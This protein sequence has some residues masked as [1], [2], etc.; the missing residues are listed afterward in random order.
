MTSAIRKEFAA[1]PTPAGDLYRS[2]GLEFVDIPLPTLAGN[3]QD[4]LYSHEM[5]NVDSPRWDLTLEQRHVV[6]QANVIVMDQHI[7][8]PLFIAPEENL[9]ECMRDILR[10]INWVQGTY[11]GVEHY[12]NRLAKKKSSEA[13]PFVLTRAGAL[14]PR[15]MGQYVFGYVT[16]FE[17]KLLEAIDFRNKGEYARAQMANFRL[18]ENV[19]IGILGFGE[20]GQGIGKMLRS[21]GYNVIGFKRRIGANLELASSADHVTADLN[22]VLSKSDYLVNVLPSTSSTQYLLNETNLKLCHER[23]PTFINIGR[24]DVASEETIISALNTGM[25]SR[26]V[27]DVFEQEPLPRESALWSHPAVM[28]TPHVARFPFAEDGASVFVNNFNL[29]LRGE[30]MQYQVDWKDGY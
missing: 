24:G 1:S 9:P 17:R 3:T 18:P 22:E 20:I 5:D 13:P 7:G 30:T 29:Y 2:N 4:L 16:M 14:F 19:T 8:G 21:A 23:K 15:I 28:F 12:L 25:W 27:L 6:E 10:N 11:A 26:A